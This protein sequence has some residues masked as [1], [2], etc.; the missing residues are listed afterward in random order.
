MSNKKLS[1]SDLRTFQQVLKA[2]NTDTEVF[3][4]LT[5]LAHQ[6]KAYSAYCNRKNYTVTL[7]SG[8]KSTLFFSQFPPD[9]LVIT[10]STS[11]PELLQD[12]PVLSQL[13][14]P[15]QEERQIEELSSQSLESLPLLE[16]ITLQ[17]SSVSPAAPKVKTPKLSYTVRLDE[18]DRARLQAIA[19]IDDIP[20]S[21]VL[22]A[23]IKF[24]L[25]AA[26]K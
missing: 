19:D 5:S 12:N 1:S 20:M 14:E 22:R 2:H 7:R 4:A 13:F 16:P 8:S 10:H 17:S 26:K 18:S 25:K 9:K 6:V 3:K 21:Q 15:H 23:A 11:F 24:Y